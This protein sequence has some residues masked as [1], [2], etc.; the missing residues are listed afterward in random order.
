MAERMTAVAAATVGDLLKIKGHT[1]QQLAETTGLSIR[2]LTRFVRSDRSAERMAAGKHSIYVAGYAPDKNGRSFVPI[3]R[4]GR[5]REDA[6][7]PG[8][9]LTPAE[10]M[11]KSRRKN[12]PAAE[13][14]VKV[15]IPELQPEYEPL[16]ILDELFG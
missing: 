11:R 1:Y 16:S 9:M 10:Q 7:R 15:P 2:A 4:W 6:P 14:K 5:G 8:R 12:R 3:W 13:S